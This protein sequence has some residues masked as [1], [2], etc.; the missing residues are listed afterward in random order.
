MIRRG[1]F[2]ISDYSNL[3]GK[4]TRIVIYND[5]TT[6]FWG[7]LQSHYVS[8]S[9]HR[10]SIDRT[11]TVNCRDIRHSTSTDLFFFIFML[12]YKFDLVP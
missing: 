6:T 4:N 12:Y 10:G 7:R 8:L 1:Q 3:A 2:E 9:P 5:K 11:N